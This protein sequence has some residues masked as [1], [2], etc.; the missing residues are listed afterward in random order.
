MALTAPGRDGATYHLPPGATLF[1]F[2]G[3]F[4]GDFSLD[5]DAPSITVQVPPGEYRLSLFNSNGDTTVWPL[6]R[7]NADGTTEIVPATLDLTPMITVAANETTNL[8]IRF[9]VQSTGTIIFG[10]GDVNVSVEVDEA[11]ASVDVALTVSPLTVASIGSGETT[12]AALPPRLP[13]LGEHGD[14]Y[15][16]TLQTTGPWFMSRP[17]VVCAPVA[18]TAVASG[19]QGFVD[20]VAE[21]APTGGELVCIQQIDAEHAVIFIRFAHQGPATTSLLSDLGDRQFFIDHGITANVNAT[22][23]DGTTL[24][25]GVLTGTRS[26]PM[27]VFGNI[28]AEVDTGI[29]GWYQV[30]EFGD[31]TLTLTTH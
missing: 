14:G 18:A 16:V 29:D 6:T 2:N 24:D 9:H 23:F 4:L 1:L 31:G 5:A 12:P 7:R 3:R 15:A 22:V 21:G 20:L 11:V 19:N 30:N 13:A 25:L 8:V 10:K 27:N 17:N 28:A 26:V